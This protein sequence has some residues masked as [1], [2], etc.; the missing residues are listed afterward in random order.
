MTMQWKN[1]HV[2]HKEHERSRSARPYDAVEKKHRLSLA[3]RQPTPGARNALP[4]GVSWMT[5]KI[6]ATIRRDSRSP[7]AAPNLCHNKA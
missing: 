1:D 3:L 7:F 6:C 5:R 4:Q 2:R